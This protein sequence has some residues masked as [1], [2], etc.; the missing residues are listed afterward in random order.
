MAK[1][2]Y[3]VH[4][5]AVVHGTAY[6]YIPE[7]E[8]LKHFMDGSSDIEWDFAELRNVE[9]GDIEHIDCIPDDGDT[10]EHPVVLTDDI[11]F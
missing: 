9:T 7:G 5:T 10:E 11:P 3:A 8:K 6:Y 4:Y 2:V 1:D